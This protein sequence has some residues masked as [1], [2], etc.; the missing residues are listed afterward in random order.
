MDL[1]WSIVR[2]CRKWTIWARWRWS[3]LSLPSCKQTFRSLWAVTSW[4]NQSVHFLACNL[5]LITR[6]HRSSLKLLPWQPRFR[7]QREI[8]QSLRIN[9]RLQKSLQSSLPLP[10]LLTSP[11]TRTSRSRVIS[12]RKSRKA[13]KG[14]VF[15][16]LCSMPKVACLGSRVGKSLRRRASLSACSI[17][18]FD[19]PMQARGAKHELLLLLLLLFFFLIPLGNLIFE[20]IT[21]SRATLHLKAL[22]VQEFNDWYAWRELYRPLVLFLRAGSTLLAKPFSWTFLLEVT[23][24]LPSALC[25]WR[26]KNAWT[27]KSDL[28][29]RQTLFVQCV[30]QKL[31]RRRRNSSFFSW[32]CY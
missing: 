27:M 15:G 10:L 26:N 28:R 6:R 9:R 8:H 30:L 12:S 7:E 19:H 17:P 24:H 31:G 11:E 1:G 4:W 22:N 32:M 29:H 5:F 3:N 20:I 16:G 18:P 23:S 14:G 25:S 2:V 13:S 21:K